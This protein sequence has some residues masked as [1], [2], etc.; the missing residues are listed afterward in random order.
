M[1]DSS[2]PRPIMDLPFTPRSSN[3]RENGITSTTMVPIVRMEAL[4][5]IADEVCVP[6]ISTSTRKEK[7][8]SFLSHKRVSVRENEK[9]NNVSSI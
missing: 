6:S 9:I 3:S 8:N 7:S 2:A 5:A 4:V 1:E